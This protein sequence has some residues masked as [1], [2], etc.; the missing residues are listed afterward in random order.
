MLRLEE[1]KRSFF[2]SLWFIFLTFP[3]MVISVNPIEKVVEWRLKNL[4]FDGVGSF[5]LSFVWRYFL[6]SGE[7]RKSKA[8]T[9]FLTNHLC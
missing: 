7:D 3:I 9:D 6:V 4:F 1:I 2:V 8:E 5:F